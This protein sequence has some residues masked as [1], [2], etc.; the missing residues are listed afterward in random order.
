MGS[1]G[2]FAQAAEIALV[3]VDG[4]DAEAIARKSMKI[5][6]DMCV[7]TNHHLTIEILEPKEDAPASSV[8]TENR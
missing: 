6:G 2:S 4:I 3:D 7:Y 5:A 1:G 8:T